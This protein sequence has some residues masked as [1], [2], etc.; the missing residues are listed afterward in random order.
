LAG[1]E[2]A[3]RR[4]VETGRIA[5]E[6]QQARNQETQALGQV[7]VSLIGWLTAELNKIATLIS[8][9]SIEC[10]VRDAGMPNGQQPMVKTGQTSMYRLLNGVELTFE[11]VNDPSNRDHV[12]QFFLC[13]HEKFV[14]TVTVVDRAP[15]PKAE[16][17]RDFE[18]AVLPFYRQTLRHRH[19]NNPSAMGYIS[20]KNMIGTLCGHLDMPQGVGQNTQPQVHY[21]RV[22]LISASFY[23]DVTLHAAFCASEWPDNEEQLRNLLKESIDSFITRINSV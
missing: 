23:N 22:E 21:E 1:I 8:S 9:D 6:N 20:R 4:S 2:Q 16:P 14:A 3:Q 11:D 17:V 19:P 10:D 13:K 12:L 5:V 7:Q 15:P 18:L